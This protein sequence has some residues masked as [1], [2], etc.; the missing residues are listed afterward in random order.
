MKRDWLRGLA[1]GLFATGALLAGIG[2]ERHERGLVALSFGCFAA[3]VLAFLRWR[4]AN[5]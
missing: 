4:A 5:R 3:G 1:V 2:N